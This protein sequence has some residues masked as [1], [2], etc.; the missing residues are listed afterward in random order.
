MKEKFE[1]YFEGRISSSDQKGLLTYLRQSEKER[2]D[3]EEAKEV[4][5]EKE[6]RMISLNTWNAWKNI[7]K[8]VKPEFRIRRKWLLSIA[9]VA[10]I[11][12]L[13]LSVSLLTVK[14]K[15]LSVQTNAGQLIEVY[16]PDSSK[17]FVN[18]DSKVTYRTKWLGL[19]REVHLTGEAF[20]EVA[21]E[22][23]R[24]FDVL[25]NDVRV[26]VT[27]TK[28]NV[29]AY[30]R[31][32]V[33]VVLEDGSVNLTLDNDAD[34]NQFL[35]PGELIRINSATKQYSKNKARVEDYTSWKE[36]MLYFR[37]NKLPNLLQSIERRYGVIFNKIEDP[38]LKEFT[39][40]FAIR[41]EQFE[42]V[43]DI[44]MAAL[45]VKVQTV[46]G[47]VVIQLDKEKYA[48]MKNK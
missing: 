32:E 41:N 42:K 46:S 22:A 13:V 25:A 30:E 15:S 24:G 40:T 9:S 12:I 23:I 6:N 38:I 14:S 2:A 8:E 1:K 43:M 33:T 16:L 11:I 19:K 34:F 35:K 28:F 48:R 20:F 4:W 47:V 7:E 31:E 5:K 3:F 18:S 27:G 36:G 37:N 21:H 45:P 39:L 44:I 26:K 17:V 29:K 10:S